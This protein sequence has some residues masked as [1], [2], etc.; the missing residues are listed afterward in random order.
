LSRVVLTTKQKETDMAEYTFDGRWLK[1]RSGQ[2]LGEIDRTSIRAWNGAR[3]GEI[4][5]KNIR[6]AHAKK[7]AEFDGKKVK[8]DMGNKIATLEQIQQT[9]DGDVGM[10]MVALWYFFVKK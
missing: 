10:P 1:N 2:K 4:D 6:D 9:I 5:R 8:D 3:L 7:V